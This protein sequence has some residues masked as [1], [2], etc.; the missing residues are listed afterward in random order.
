MGGSQQSQVTAEIRNT[1]KIF[2][3]SVK[4]K[5][6]HDKYERGSYH[7]ERL[8]ELFLT[9]Q[10][11]KNFLSLPNQEYMNTETR[12]GF[13]SKW[14]K[15]WTITECKLTPS[16]T[17]TLQHQKAEGISSTVQGIVSRE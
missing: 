9:R 10:S 16:P 12:H 7:A 2:N 17:V 11:K 1:Y 5:P 15:K 14:Q 13:K 8:R 6:K 4:G 3:D